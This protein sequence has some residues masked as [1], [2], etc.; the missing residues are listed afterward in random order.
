MTPRDKHAILLQ[1]VVR[2]RRVL[3]MDGGNTAENT[4]AFEAAEAA[5]R[6]FKAG[7]R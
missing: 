5:F 2:A 4:A 1:A 3:F 7:G 6:A